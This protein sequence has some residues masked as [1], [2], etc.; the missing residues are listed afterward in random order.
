GYIGS[1]IDI[2]ER[3]QAEAR[4]REQATLLEKANDAI[5]VRDLD[6]RIAYWNQGAERLY[7]WPAAEACGHAADELLARGPAEALDEARR[8]VLER[9]EWHGELR[10]ATRAGPEVVV[11]SRWTLV[12]DEQGKP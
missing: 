2:T 8:Q 4:V 6:G 1:A 5:L 9:G 7:G 12:R 3:K 10:Q 11:A